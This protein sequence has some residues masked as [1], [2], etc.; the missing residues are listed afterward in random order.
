MV[1]AG[2]HLSGGQYNPAVTLAVLVRRRIGLRDAAAYWVV[3]LGA[4]VLAAVVLRTVIEP[5]Q[6]VTPCG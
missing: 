4:G 3:Q 6:M 5:A 2:G 1:S